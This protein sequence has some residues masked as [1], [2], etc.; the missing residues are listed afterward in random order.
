MSTATIFQRNKRLYLD[1]ESKLYESIQDTS[2]ATQFQL[3][4]DSTIAD[5]DVQFESCEQQL[6]ELQQSVA[7][8]EGKYWCSKTVTQHCNLHLDERRLISKH[9]ATSGGATGAD[10]GA[11]AGNAAAG[12]QQPS[13]PGSASAGAVLSASHPSWPDVI[14]LVSCLHQ[15][16]SRSSITPKQSKFVEQC[17]QEFQHVVF[18]PR[19]LRHI[20]DALNTKLLDDVVTRSVFTELTKYQCAIDELAPDLAQCEELLDAALMNGEV[21]LAEDISKK[22]LELYEH[23]LKLICEQYPIIHTHHTEA[24]EHQRRRRWAIFRMASRDITT[25]VDSKTRQ[26]EACEED[27]LKIR[28]QLQNYNRDDNF[29]RKRYEE[30]RSASDTFLT[31]NKEKQQ[32]CWNRI[33]E[34]FQQLQGCQEQLGTLAQQRRKEI[35]RR[36]ALEER[37]AGRRSGHDSFIHAAAAHAQKLQDTIDNA[38]AARE[39]AK[40]LNAFVLDGSDSVTAKYD[41]QQASLNEMLRLVQHHHFKRYSDYTIAGSRYLYRKQKALDNISAEIRSAEMQR[42]L[43]AETLDPRAKKHASEHAG[44]QYRKRDVGEEVLT[45]R[46]K[47]DAAE[48]AIAPTLQSFAFHGIPFVHPR[49]IADKMNTDRA[50]K[51]LD[52]RDIVNPSVPV[53]DRILKDEET[54]LTQLKTLTVQAETAREEK[55]RLVASKPRAPGHSQQQ[56]ASFQRFQAIL[57]R[58]LD[59]PTTQQ[60]QQLASSGGQVAASGTAQKQLTSV[61]NSIRSVTDVVPVVADGGAAGPSSSVALSTGGGQQQNPDGQSFRALY[62]YKARAADELSFE[63]GDIVV[64]IAAAMEEGW[65]R[66]VSNQRTGLFPMNYVS[67]LVDT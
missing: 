58:K 32:G 30:D 10:G 22:Q 60:Q 25:V 24:V 28:D 37:E 27:L 43:F 4:L 7:V 21:A 53:G 8:D 20:A 48:K 11:G 49:E 40:S 61:N 51:I 46:H 45:I 52:Y 34:L 44:L 19:E 50:S 66:G 15:L 65:C 42:E 14:Q 35:D 1:E 17:E 39:L 18:E 13:S 29:Q 62:R 16:K 6:S 47:L 36:L 67:P 3:W 54:Q 56:S 38:I 55:A 63:K 5:L 59:T 12:N 41:R 57:D 31:Q 9:G 64:C 2:F 33:Y 26:V 23:M